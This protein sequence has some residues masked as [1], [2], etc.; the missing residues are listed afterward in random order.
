ML[1]RVSV[2]G[3]RTPDAPP[4]VAPGVWEIQQP[5]T[6]DDRAGPPPP[7][8]GF[9]V[10]GWLSLR[11]A[12]D[13]MLPGGPRYGR[14]HRVPGPRR[15]ARTTRGRPARANPDRSVGSARQ[16]TTQRH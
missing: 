9:L 5:L 2:R 7:P 6:Y 10:T 1:F 15:P 4:G 3:R 14:V 16:A 8:D 12:L 13:R 11:R